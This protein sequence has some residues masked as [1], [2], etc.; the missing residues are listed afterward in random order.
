MDTDQQN[1]K[2]IYWKMGEV[3]RLLC[4]TQ[5]NARFWIESFKL[6]F[7]RTTNND[8]LFNRSEIETML[9][10]KYLLD[11]EMYTIPG[12]KIKLKM[13]LKKKYVI[14]DEY[15]SITMRSQTESLYFD[16]EVH[17]PKRGERKKP[18]PEVIKVLPAKPSPSQLPS[19]L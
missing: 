18:I 2:K 4:I 5:S 12:A 14:P 7:K 10:I 11:K 8:R 6:E 1:I 13:W 3:A 16:S 17:K 19:T 15:L 9:A